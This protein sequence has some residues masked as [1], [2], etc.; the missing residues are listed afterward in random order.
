[1]M[2]SAPERHLTLNGHAFDLDRRHDLALPITPDEAT[3]AF[4]L[5]PASFEPFR[6][7]GFVGSIEEGGPVRCDV[8]TLAPHGNGTHTECVGHIA[9]RSYTVDV[10]MRDLVDTATLVSVELTESGGDLVVSRQA[11]LAAWTNSAAATLVIRTLPNDASKRT[12]RWSSTNPPYID[13]D[14]MDLIVERGVR[15]LMVDLPSVDPEEDQGALVA[16]H[17]FWQWPEN[18]RTD[19]TIT[20][21]IFVPDTIPDGLYAVMFNIAPFHGDAAPSRPVLMHLTSTHTHQSSGTASV[22]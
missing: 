14:A 12:R 10:C 2:Q 18:P 20:E 22:R 8:V 16:H 9:G 17:R 13:I 4:S 5:P 1:M 21:L 15:H 11:L 3:N 7:G 6:V 19:C